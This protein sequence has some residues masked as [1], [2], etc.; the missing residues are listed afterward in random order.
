MRRYYGGQACSG[1]GYSRFPDSR[2]RSCWGAVPVSDQNYGQE[3]ADPATTEGVV[4]H[5]Q[6]DCREALELGMTPTLPEVDGWQPIMLEGTFKMIGDGVRTGFCSCRP[7]D[8][9]RVS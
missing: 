9:R 5:E 1:L 4:L 2:W 7:P 3:Y 6:L 8:T